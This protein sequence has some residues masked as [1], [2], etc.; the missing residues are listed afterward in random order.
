MKARTG[1]RRA[2]W[3]VA[4][5]LLGLVLLIVGAAAYVLST[6]PF[7]GKL[8][9]ERLARARA[10]PQYQNGVFVNPLPPAGY[11]AADVW[12]MFTGQ[13][14]GGEA[15]FASNPAKMRCALPKL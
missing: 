13:F 11:R 12:A 2:R 6:P 1:A 3:W 14:F 4:G 10:N 7:G 5:V 8:T 9:G 15:M